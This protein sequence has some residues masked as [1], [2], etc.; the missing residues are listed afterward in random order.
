MRLTPEEIRNMTWEGIQERMCGLR[1]MVY[2][3]LG[4]C[5]EPVTTRQLAANMDV[6]VLNV[7]PRVSEL[8]DFGLAEMV[9]SECGHRKREGTYRAVPMHQAR[10][11]HDARH[12]VGGVP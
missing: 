12:A 10:A 6:D 9:G 7:R 4:E 11:A 5:P 8:V 1:H 2:I 3:A